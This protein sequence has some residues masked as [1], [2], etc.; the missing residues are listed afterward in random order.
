[1]TDTINNTAQNPLATEPI[2]KLIAK[3]AI[4]AIISFLVSAI[5]NIV[6]QIFIGQGV[7]LLGNAATN[8]AF[9]LT[10]IS[11]AIALLIG[12]GSASNFNLRLGEGHKDKAGHIAG[13]GITLMIAFGVTLAVVVIAFLDPLLMAFGSTPNVLPYAQTYTGITTLGIPFIIQM[14]IRDSN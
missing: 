8:V 7:G 3:F 6:D 5:Y 9:P 11:T 14:C 12:V 10:T 1:M 4:P 2:G 13:T